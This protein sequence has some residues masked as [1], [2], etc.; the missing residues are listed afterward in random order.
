VLHYYKFSL[1]RYIEI[2]Q[3]LFELED[4]KRLLEPPWSMPVPIIVQLKQRSKNAYNLL[5]PWAVTPALLLRHR[6]PWKSEQTHRL[7][8]GSASLCRFV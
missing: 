4:W 3:S 1:E 8:Q 6:H 7:S 2:Q 5:S